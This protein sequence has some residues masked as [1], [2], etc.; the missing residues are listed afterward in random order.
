[1]P[2]PSSPR[3]WSLPRLTAGRRAPLLLLVLS[4]AVTVTAIVQAQHAVRSHRATAERLLGKYGSFAA[5]SY[6]QHT[7]DMLAKAFRA[8][9]DTAMT[10][11][12]KQRPLPPVTALAVYERKYA[13]GTECNPLYGA[14]FYFR[15]PLD[16]G[17]LEVAG[18]EPGAAA[19]R[20][21]A[22]TVRAAAPALRTAGHAYGVLSARVGGA[23][24]H[25]VYTLLSAPDGTRWA[26]GFELD[27][28]RYRPLFQHVI[29]EESLLPTTA[30]EGRRGIDILS[31]K[32]VSPGVGVLFRSGSEA[33]WKFA[34]EDSLR[35]GYGSLVV[36]AA[37]RPEAAGLLIIGGLPRSRLP[38]LLGMLALSVMLAAVAV[39]QLRREA[40][41]A[42]MRS[43]FVSSVSHELRTPLA[44]VRLFLE[45]LRLGRWRTE[46]QREWL[47]ANVDRE[48]T[49]LT[50]LVDNVLHFSRSERGARGGEMEVV[51]LAGYLDGVVQSF[52]PLAAARRVAFETSAEPGLVARMDPEAF[53]QVLLNLL[54]NAVKYGPQG[55]TVRVSAA[56]IAE[57]RVAVAVEDEG[58]GIDPAE[59]E[60]VWEP[61]RRGRKAV[62]SAAAGSGIG[63]S[64][65]REIVAWH[66]GAARVE[67]GVRGAR[68]VVE[69]PG[70]IVPAGPV[71]TPRATGI[72]AA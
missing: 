29:A 46:Q 47:L 48:T 36:R 33:G 42:R 28:A 54:D 44:Q 3:R 66:G 60:R 10:A 40:E 52:A 72:A 56:S 53:R 51:E 50:N 41:L 11:A 65:V 6:R 34:G 31:V 49:R 45:T 57:G 26:Y 71:E 39:S 21:I 55:Q 67:D 43:D 32:V 38:L 30:L 23:P 69:V 15:V 4:L 12:E 19:R 24:R 58:P 14:P 64:V 59:R 9:L 7:A 63:L 68:I 25:L 20:W 8:T 18:A 2:P 5:W 37:V 16:S 27:P 62:G 17:S 1:M 13:P 61:F 35:G 70:W 22:D